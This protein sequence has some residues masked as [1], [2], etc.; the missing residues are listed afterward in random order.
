[1][2]WYIP[3]FFEPFSNAFSK[4]CMPMYLHHNFNICLSFSMDPHISTIAVPK[5]H[6]NGLFMFFIILPQLEAL[7]EIL[8][9][10]LLHIHIYICFWIATLYSG[11]WLC[12]T[13]QL[14]YIVARWKL[15]FYLHLLLAVTSTHKYLYF[16]RFSLNFFH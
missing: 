4:T 7:Y 15:I 8:P 10:I 3:M 2:K 16:N 13:L 12:P 9:L 1:M 11:E 5:M 14:L 6:I